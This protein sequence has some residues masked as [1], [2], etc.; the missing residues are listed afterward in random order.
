MIAS[1]AELSKQLGHSRAATFQKYLSSHMRIDLQGLC[2]DGI[3]RTDHIDTLRGVSLSMRPGAPMQ[4]PTS[5]KTQFRKDQKYL[6][7]VRNLDE[8]SIE[9]NLWLDKHAITCVRYPAAF[10][11]K[12]D[13]ESAWA[14]VLLQGG[15]E[16]AIPKFCKNL[17]NLVKVARAPENYLKRAQHRATKTFRQAWFEEET[18]KDSAYEE[19]RGGDLV[20]AP[21]APK[22]PHPRK[23]L[24]AYF[25]PDNKPMG[26]IDVN[27]G[28]NI[29]QLLVLICK[30]DDRFRCKKSVSADSSPEDEGRWKLEDDSWVWDANWRLFQNASVVEGALVTTIDVPEIHSRIQELPMQRSE[31]QRMSPTSQNYGTA[32]KAKKR[33]SAPIISTASWKRS[34]YYHEEHPA[35]VSAELVQDPVTG[36]ERWVNV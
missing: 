27:Q 1:E 29:I 16:L 8:L 34:K 19:S 31:T 28:T 36:V 23:P 33:R 22:E 5:V 12:K 3:A 24:L 4:I 15:P 30:N 20:A 18:R 2:T 10:Y 25:C 17:P 26:R 14:L 32:A 7:L 6:D 9:M 21:T 11:T 35:I 13:A